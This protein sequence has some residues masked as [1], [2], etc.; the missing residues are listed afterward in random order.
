MITFG[1]NY[2]VKQEF[3]DEFVKVSR[4]VL[5]AMPG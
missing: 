2:D 5:K 4:D 1:L 3:V